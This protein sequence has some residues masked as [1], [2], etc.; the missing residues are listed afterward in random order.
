DPECRS[1][2]FVIRWD[3]N[4]YEEG[5]A[6]QHCITIVEIAC[7][8]L[9]FAAVELPVT[10]TALSLRAKVFFQK[11]GGA[12]RGELGGAS[13]P[14]Q[15]GRGFMPKY[16]SPD[17]AF[18]KSKNV[19]SGKWG[20]DGFEEM[21]G[22][23]TSLKRVGRLRVGGRMFGRSALIKK[24]TIHITNLAPTVTSAD[25]RELF[26][27]YTIESATVNYDEIGESAGSAD[28]VTD[29]ASAEEIINN[30]GGIALDGRTMHMF[31]I[32][33]NESTAPRS[34]RIK[35]RLNFQVVPRSRG[36]N[37]RQERRFFKTG[38]GRI[39]KSIGRGWKGGSIRNE[40]DKR[41][42][43]TEAELDRELDEYMK[44]GGSAQKMQS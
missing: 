17:S 43:M 10:S 34:F 18:T 42:K 8:R 2:P 3:G 20:H 15:R 21:Y 37:K 23:G 30:F 1:T 16:E 24:V 38:G 12:K 25:L 19:P 36:I 31:V 26:E 7:A 5:S 39:P 22:S 32:D 11:K 4:W 13:R 29:R 6:K 41:K 9:R 14:R 40:G 35:E 44:K 33:E 28:V 27:D